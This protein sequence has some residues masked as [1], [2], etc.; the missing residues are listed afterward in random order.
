[1]NAVGWVVLTYCILACAIAPVW[2]WWRTRVKARTGGSCDECMRLSRALREARTTA[3]SVR[4]ALRRRDPRLERAADRGHMR[5]TVHLLT[6]PDTAA[7]I[8]EGAAEGAHD[9]WQREARDG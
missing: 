6:H 3:A 9:A 7:A 8:W 4:V 2:S 5:L 1:M